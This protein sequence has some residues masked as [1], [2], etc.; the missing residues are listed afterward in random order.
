MQKTNTFIS[1]LPKN[2]FSGFVVSLIALPL[3]LG[4]A[5]ASGVPPI[6]GIITA[7]VGG[8][9]VAILG[10]SHVTITG[11]G[12]GL[13]VVVLASVMTLGAGD[14]YQGYLYTLAAVVLSGVLVM[15]FGFLRLG[16]LS[17][18]FP[19]SAIQGMLAAIGLGIF[20][21]QFHVML[22]N[23]DASGSIVELLLAIPAAILEYIQTNQ[24]SAIWAGGIGILSLM[25]M[26]FY[27][28]I[29]NRLFQLVPAP[30]WI[31]VLCVGLFYYLG[32]EYPIDS[33]FLISIPDQVFSK[34]P[35]PDFGLWN[36][37]EF[38]NIVITLTLI[39]SIESL[40]SI[41]AVD[42][43]DPLKRRSNVNRDLKA[44]GFATVVSGFIGGLN[45]VTVIARSSVNVNNNG[46]NRSANLFHSSFLV[47]FILLFASQLKMVPLS[48]L[49]AILV[50]TGYKLANP[51]NMIKI[52]K[53]GKEQL[54]IFLTTLLVTLFTNLITGI[55]AG[56]LM[57][58]LIHVYLCR[59]LNFFLK[60]FL[61]PNVLMYKEDEE[62]NSYYV[63]VTDFCTF[64]NYFRLKK[65][66]DQIPENTKV[67]VDL[68]YCE[69]VD[70]TVM[71]NLNNYMD[72]FERKGGNFECMG[73]DAHG[74]KS[75]H[76]FAM[77]RLLPFKGKLSLNFTARQRKIKAVAEE[78]EY[79]Y[80]LAAPRSEFQLEQ[81]PFFKTKSIT[82]LK[83]VLQYEGQ[84]LFDVHFSEGAFIAKQEVKMTM[85]KLDLK[86]KV[87]SFVLN[88]DEGLLEYIYN[89]NDYNDI[90]IEGYPDFSD[91][92]YLSGIDEKSIKSF[93]KDELI[94]FFESNLY[95]HI[96]S[97]EQELLI[98]KRERLASVQELKLFLDFGLRLKNLLDQDYARVEI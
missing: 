50:F 5:L 56:I 39:A 54:A 29:R 75:A 19:A 6:A 38:I 30:M 58:F 64:L 21:K 53:V 60:N 66:L 25:I 59:S 37:P 61:K 92:F 87:P 90:K 45:V 22:G 82:T 23:D 32:P 83:N 43:L 1:D 77:R 81:F 65:Q 18:F 7:I 67:I 84:S 17:D 36:T 86:S 62:E 57:T 89:L 16:L 80:R 10:G 26:I 11:P 27:P 8:T 85:M 88:K 33:S 3:G 63:S 13:V 95:Y 24:E 48:A 70:H 98:L 34:F 96:E 93:F 94:R 4:L 12:N 46:S 97:S 15:L 47:I 55:L 51:V 52:F 35:S 73:L 71:E 20:A 14:A 41:K 91:R 2:I 72:A 31:V 78:F 42:K 68:S 69:F 79:M 44:L 74:A 40:L 49:A 76:P 9:L 28:K